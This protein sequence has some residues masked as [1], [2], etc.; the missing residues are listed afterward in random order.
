MKIKRNDILRILIFV[1]FLYIKADGM[2][3]TIE[4]L[5]HVAVYIGYYVDLLIRYPCFH[6]NQ[7]VIVTDNF[8]QSKNTSYYELIHP[9]SV[10]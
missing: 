4:K 7:R 10:L 2:C 6:K 3:P 9:A 8:L 1:A 5:K